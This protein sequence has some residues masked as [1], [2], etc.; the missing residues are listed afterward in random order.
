MNKLILGSLDTAPLRR[1]RAT[2][3]RS[4][5]EDVVDGP[6]GHKEID[7]F[8]KGHE[9]ILHYLGEEFRKVLADNENDLADVAGRLKYMG[10]SLKI[11][12]TCGEVAVTCDG[13]CREIAKVC[14]SGIHGEIGGLIDTLEYT[15][16][17]ATK[18]A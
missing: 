15:K 17:A 13:L 16:L 10:A 6:N 4:A 14:M 3:F 7:I 8:V 1:E 18:A 9:P 5:M 2:F 11:L 12:K